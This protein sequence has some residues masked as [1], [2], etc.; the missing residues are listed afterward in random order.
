LSFVAPVGA[1][2]VWDTYWTSKIDAGNVSIVV[3]CSYPLVEVSECMT[4]VYVWP[5]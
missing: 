2:Y 3:S 5:T 1:V 4:Y